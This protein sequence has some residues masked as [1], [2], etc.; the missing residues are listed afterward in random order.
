MERGGVPE[1]ITV[2]RDVVRAKDVRSEVLADGH[3]GYIRIDS[4]SSGVA[5][6]FRDSLE[7]QLAAG[8]TRFVLDV[9]DDPGGFVDAAVSVASQFVGSG[10]ILWEED[11]D[12][13]QRPFPA[14][15]GGLATDPG[16]ELVVLVNDGTASA[17]EILAG[18]LRDAERAVLVGQPTFGKGSVQE[19][20]SCRGT[21]AG[22]GCRWRAG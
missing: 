6:D 3:V 17:S 21:P 2:E 7:E 19:W 9:R 8:V 4:F 10:A 12:G 1:S 18:A 15:A 5:E 14:E 16:I 11:A 20:H 13:T 22:S